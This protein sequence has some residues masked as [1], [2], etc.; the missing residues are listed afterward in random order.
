MEIPLNFKPWLPPG[1]FRIPIPREEQT[2]KEATT[3]TEVIDSDQQQ[4]EVP[5]KSALNLWI[6]SP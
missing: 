1:H 5:E 2:R 6:L 4:E 3:F